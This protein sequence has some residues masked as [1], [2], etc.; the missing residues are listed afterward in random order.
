MTTWSH[1]TAREWALLADAPLAAAAAVA[2]SSEGGGR[3]EASAMIA[4]WREAARELAASPLVAELAAR[5]DPEDREQRDAGRQIGPPPS[6]D[7]LLDEALTLC[8]RAVGLL[9]AAAPAELDDYRAFVLQICRR[10]ANANN[11]A[12]LLSLGGDAVSRDERSVMRL[13]ARA[14]GA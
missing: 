9:D 12:G 5:L 13:I 14:L 4:G 1:L 8:E 3:R 6:F 10:V 7:E 11:E 2:L